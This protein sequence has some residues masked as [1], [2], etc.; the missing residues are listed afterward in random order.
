MKKRLFLILSLVALTASAL[1]ML[2]PNDIGPRLVVPLN[3][4]TIPAHRKDPV[5]K[6]QKFVSLSEAGQAELF[7]VGG[8]FDFSPVDGVSLG[9][10]VQSVETNEDGSL[11]SQGT[12]VGEPGS[13]AVFSEV[14]G[15]VAGSVELAD[16]RLFTINYVVPGV[17]CTAEVDFTTG[18]LDCGSCDDERPKDLPRGMV[19][20][21]YGGNSN[22]QLRRSLR[23]TRPSGS[24]T[25][26]RPTTKKPTTKKPSNSS[27]KKSGSG[28]GLNK[29][30]SKKPNTKKSTTKKSSSAS[31]RIDLMVVYTPGAAKMFGGE[32]GIKARVN[33]A[34]SRSNKAFSDSK[35]KA[36][37]NLVHA[38]QVNYTSDGKMSDDLMNV[39]IRKTE[40]KKQVAKLR[41]KY[42]ADLITLV[43][44]KA[45]GN[46]AGLGFLLNRKS[47]SP[48]WGFN[49]VAGR[50][51]Y[52]S[53]LAHECGHNL[54]CTHDKSN[55]GCKPM[56]DYGY[57]WRFHASDGKNTRQYRTIM[58]YAPG[59]RIGYFSNPNVKYNGVPTGV[60]NQADNARVINITA[61]IVARNSEQK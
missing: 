50:A 52:Y 22:G 34:V 28:C 17:H 4:V 46:V 60:A 55:S 47:P 53:V 44:E 43:T 32:K 31:A 33:V 45:P 49:V 15:A 24:G 18:L 10:E 30:T 48:Q 37:L 29:S 20:E 56:D 25:K 11:L 38:G 21:Y 27:K 5:A 16:G 58:A 35:I 3:G 57:G 61:A 54:G 1:W 23:G 40:L 36:S 12:V 13:V 42:K 7:R 41:K 59:N 51:L 9:V 8:R 2:S 14:K 19:M 39:S 26:T 6:A